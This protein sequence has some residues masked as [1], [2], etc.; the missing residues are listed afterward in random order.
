LKRRSDDKIFG[1]CSL[2]K[3]IQFAEQH[4]VESLYFQVFIGDQS[5]GWRYLNNGLPQGSVL[6]KILFNLYISD[7]PST[8]AKVF[9]YAEDIAVTYPAKKC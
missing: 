7:L 6:A 1:S 9:Q 5:S 2:L 3:A 8:A 4:A